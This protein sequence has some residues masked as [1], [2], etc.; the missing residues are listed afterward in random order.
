MMPMMRASGFAIARVAAIPFI[1]GVIAGALCV[2]ASGNHPLGAWIGAIA[3]AA[4]ILP[5]L[6]RDA[7][8]R[9][10]LFFIAAATVDGLATPLLACLFAGRMT[11]LQWVLCYCVLVAFGFALM[12]PAR[13]IRPIP[14][15]VLA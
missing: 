5:P 9:C 15:V 10:S 13:M 6:T 1:L 3:L 2:T 11:I 4:L 12:T 14:T 7:I 8:D